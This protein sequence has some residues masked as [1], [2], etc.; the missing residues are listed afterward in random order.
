MP[1]DVD[2]DD[3]VMPLY[4]A[5]VLMPEL[6]VVGTALVMETLYGC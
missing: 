3:D 5:D 6:V 1:V 2:D 4:G